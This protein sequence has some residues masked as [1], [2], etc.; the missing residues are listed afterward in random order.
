M[1]RP[2]MPTRQAHAN[3]FLFF[4]NRSVYEGLAFTSLQHSPVSG[5]IQLALTLGAYRAVDFRNSSFA[6]PRTTLRS[7]PRAG[8][9]IS[10]VV[11]AALP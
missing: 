11:F 1:V 7:H 10:G 8:V 4:T 2:L 6:I 9:L 3:S 5:K